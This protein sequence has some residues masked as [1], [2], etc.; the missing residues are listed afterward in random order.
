METIFL[1]NFI[2]LHFVLRPLD[3]IYIIYTTLQY[4][5]LHTTVCSIHSGTF[6]CVQYR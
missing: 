3:I 4:F 6:E 5:Y 2:Q 1:N